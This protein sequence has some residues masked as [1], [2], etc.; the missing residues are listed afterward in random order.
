MLLLALLMTGSRGGLVGLVVALVAGVIAAGPAC[1]KIVAAA[2][3]IVGIGV[4]YY[5]T[6]AP[7]DYVD[8]LAAVRTDGGTGRSDLWEVAVVIARDRP[9]TGV[10]A[11]NF[12]AV[13][14]RY[15]THEVDI[16]RI[17]LVLDKTKVVHNMYLSVLSE[18]G[19]VGLAFFLSLVVGALAGI[20]KALRRLRGSDWPFQLLLRGFLVGAIAILI[21][22]SFATAEYEKQLWLLL[23][24]GLALP[25]L[26]ARVPG[27]QRLLRA[28]DVLPSPRPVLPRRVGN[29]AVRT[30]QQPG[31][32][33]ASAEAA[34]RRWYRPV[35]AAEV[36]TEGRR[37]LHVTF[38]GR[39]PKR[40]ERGADVAAARGSGDDLRL[41]GLCGLGPGARGDGAPGRGR[42]AP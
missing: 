35:T 31:R 6:Y 8:R 26:A 15:A 17:D 29:R 19:V 22:Y 16:A 11:G 20:V 27:A 23:G 2:L 1:L 28:H 24:A 34:S 3:V 40:Y 13:E 4:V 42:C 25:A 37:A 38:D 36:L 7:Q 33:R 5:A 30:V 12:P 41:L 32:D 18:L 9:L 10:G 39:F 14:A 21:A